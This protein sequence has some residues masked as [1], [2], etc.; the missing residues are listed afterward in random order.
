MNSVAL[1]HIGENLP[2]Y[3]YDCIYQILLINNKGT[4]IYVCVDDI[5]VPKVRCELQKFDLCTIIKNPLNIT[6]VVQIVPL[7][8]LNDELTHDSYY[9]MYTNVL[10]TSA[11]YKD[12]NTFRG[13]FWI[14][15]T[16][17][18][19]YIKALMKVFNITNT[20]HI[21]NDVIV[22]ETFH[23]IFTN[24]CNQTNGHEKICAVKDSDN[25][26]RIVPSILYFPNL[27]EMESLTKHISNTV[28]MFSNQNAFVND[29]DILGLYENIHEFPLIPT[30]SQ[31]FFDGAAI[32]QYLGGVDPNNTGSEK[33]YLD[34]YDNP[35]V[36]FI[37]ERS[38]FKPNSLQFSKSL[39]YIDS[40]NVPL[41]LITSN[42]PNDNKLHLVANLHVH[43]KQLYKFSSIFDINFSDIITGDRILHLCD[44]VIST[45]EIFAFHQNIDYFTRGFDMSKVI[46]VKDFSNINTS[47]LNSYFLTFSHISGKTNIKL[48]IYTHL[49]D[50]FID[51]ILPVLDKS[52]TY[53]LYTHNS[54]GAFTDAHLPILQNKV[55]THVYAQNVNSQPHHKLSALPIGIANAMWKH[56]NLL[57]LYTVMKDTYK[58]K[59]ENAVYV[60]INPNTYGY[61]KEVLDAINVTGAFKIS[62]NKSY[63]DYLTELASHRFCLCLRGNGV[64][65]HRFWES[66]YLGVIPI[67]INNST[68][69]CTSFLDHLKSIDIPFV[70]LK[71][72]D[73]NELF[74]LYNN[75]YFSP[76]YYKD[77]VNKLNTSIYNISSLKLSFYGEA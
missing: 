25:P 4:K 75:T 32:G 35:T 54:D 13:G 69:K 12:K 37:N 45:K 6:D 30:T 68:T 24:F 71:G 16:A 47:L 41:K 56:G 33:R 39:V 3:I 29:M 40:V 8:I 2:S 66:L 34:I 1:I 19:F 67:V 36:G 26:P 65:T 76:S 28:R 11:V 70:E 62:Q 43:S 18:F 52:L 74:T 15:T 73:L 5:N 55:I 22:Y 61:R 17:R 72:D 58:Y 7:S 10:R 51:H 14:S 50:S 23:N 31:T 49:L 27:Q 63:K 64:D 21:E 77:F 38:R 59:K 60:N 42:A 46:I 53:T 9:N 44:F 20:F 48:F 57:E